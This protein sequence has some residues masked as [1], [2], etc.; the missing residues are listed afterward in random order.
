MFVLS[1]QRVSLSHGWKMHQCSE[2]FVI[3]DAALAGG[4]AGGEAVGSD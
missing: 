4:G 3:C 1:G 2:G